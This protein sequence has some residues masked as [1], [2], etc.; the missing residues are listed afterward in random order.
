MQ[1]TSKSGLDVPHTLEMDLHRRYGI[2]W[3]RTVQ[4]RF[5][6]MGIVSTD[7]CT[8]RFGQIFSHHADLYGTADSLPAYPHQ[9]SAS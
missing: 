4:L 5:P 2:R 3:D 8:D 6:S 9:Q 7:I 1:N